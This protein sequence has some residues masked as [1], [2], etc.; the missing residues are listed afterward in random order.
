M[1]FQLLEW[2]VTVQL[3]WLLLPAAIKHPWSL[4]L[5]ILLIIGFNPMIQLSTKIPVIIVVLWGKLHT[6]PCVTARKNV[7]FKKSLLFQRLPFYDDEWC[8]GRA[9]Q[10]CKSVSSSVSVQDCIYPKRS[11]EIKRAWMSKAGDSNWEKADWIKGL[12]FDPGS[13][14]NSTKTPDTHPGRKLHWGGFLLRHYKRKKKKATSFPT[15]PLHTCGWAAQKSCFKKRGRQEGDGWCCFWL[16]AEGGLADP[17]AW[18]WQD[19]FW[20]VCL[21][22]YVRLTWGREE[23]GGGRPRDG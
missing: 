8:K 13:Y 15:S 7:K 23:A 10:A 12:T 22:S 19:F 6:Y 1:R 17:C 18:P 11:K 21:F 5:N 2:H 3:Q 4:F 9:K 16:T 14:K 20:L